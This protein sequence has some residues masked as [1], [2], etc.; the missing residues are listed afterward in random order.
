MV[1]EC[2]RGASKHSNTR[3][4]TR[5]EPYRNPVEFHKEWGHIEDYEEVV[6]AASRFHSSVDELRHFQDYGHIED[7]DELIKE[8]P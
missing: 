8:D 4:R 2:V 3:S 1:E 6:G 5:R 7:Y